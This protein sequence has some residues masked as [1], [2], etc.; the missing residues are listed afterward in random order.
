MSLSRRKENPFDPKSFPKVN[1]Y[2]VSFSN[3][4]HFVEKDQAFSCDALLCCLGTTIKK[5]KTKKAFKEVDYEYPLAAAKILKS[6]SPHAHFL[7]ITAMG[8]DSKSVFFYN[9]VKGE[10]EQELEELKLA[11][12][13]ILRPFLIV[14]E[15]QESRFWEDVGQKV[16][17]TLDPLMAAVLN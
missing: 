13:T 6:V 5:A 11:R 8:S 10:V 9:K 2:Q 4:E 16:A 1:H 15:R 7:I 14:G 17:R 3:L 12:L